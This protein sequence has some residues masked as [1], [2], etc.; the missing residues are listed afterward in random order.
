MTVSQ[1]PSRICKLILWPLLFGEWCSCHENEHVPIL[2]C[3]RSHQSSYVDL[4]FCLM[5][6]LPTLQDD[7]HLFLLSGHTTHVYIYYSLLGLSFYC[8]LAWCVITWHI[9]FTP[10]CHCHSITLCTP[11]HYQMNYI[12]CLRLGFEPCSSLHYFQ[13]CLIH[14]IRQQMY[15][16]LCSFHLI[17]TSID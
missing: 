8:I 4:T 7:F 14:I 13:S 6:Y 15:I 3:T 9:Q 12:D 17:P 2:W 5:R 1:W 11:I 16:T 10:L